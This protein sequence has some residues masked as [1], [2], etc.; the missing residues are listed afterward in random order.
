MNLREIKKKMNTYGRI[1]KVIQ[2]MQ[3]MARNQ[4]MLCH[5][6][7]NLL[8]KM[9]DIINILGQY[10]KIDLQGDSIYII[11]FSDFGFCKNYNDVLYE[12]TA[13]TRR[14]NCFIIGK[15]MLGEENYLT[16]LR[17]DDVYSK[18]FE[19]TEGI[20]NIIFVINVG[21]KVLEYRLIDYFEPKET[22]KYILEINYEEFIN[23]CKEIFFKSMINKAIYEESMLRTEETDTAK[24]NIEE[25]LKHLVID[26]G[27]R[28]QVDITSIMLAT[29]PA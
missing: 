12:L 7:S 25:M 2:S 21:G 26:Y 6:K 28:R 20:T 8:D 23:S 3:N 14:K 22:N 24:K 4:V 5:M 18:L 19:I 17:G 11:L 27:K 9:K 29:L 15:K 13:E 16:S 1:D 10:H